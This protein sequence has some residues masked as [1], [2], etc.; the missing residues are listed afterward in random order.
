MLSQSLCLLS[1]GRQDWI[2]RST[3]INKQEPYLG[4]KK[5]RLQVRQEKLNRTKKY[6]D[7]AKKNRVVKQFKA[8]RNLFGV[9]SAG[10]VEYMICS[11]VG[12]NENQIK[13]AKSK[14]WVKENC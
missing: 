3:P 2:C 1:N 4:N 12:K 9:E 6:F 8:K 10:D 5:E 14:H 13:S 7:S 11:E